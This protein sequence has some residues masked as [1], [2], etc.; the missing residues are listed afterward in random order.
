MTLLMIVGACI[1]LM[2]FVKP[3]YYSVTAPKHSDHEMEQQEMLDKVSKEVFGKVP[4]ILPATV[5]AYKKK[6]TL[7][8]ADEDDDGF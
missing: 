1:P 6:Q 3:V 4:A 2:L 7:M 5:L 8:A